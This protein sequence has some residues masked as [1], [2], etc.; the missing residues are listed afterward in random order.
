MND[1]ALNALLAKL[2]KTPGNVTLRLA[3]IRRAVAGG[4]SSRALEL[5]LELDQ[6]NVPSADDRALI[7][8]VFSSAGLDDDA[9]MWGEAPET[10][11]EPQE[12]PLPGEPKKALRL[13]GGTETAVETPHD[14][15]EPPL[16]FADV[17]GLEQVKRDIERRIIA[18]FQQSGL[19]TRFRKKSG[20]GVLLYGPPGCGKTM[21]A[22]ATAGEC[23]FNFFSVSISD[24]LNHYVGASEKQLTAIF[25]KARS[26]T[27]SV[28]FFDEIDA[29]G[30]KRTTAS[31]THQAQ[32]VSHFLAEMDGSKTRNEGV[33]MLAATNIPWAMDPAFLRPGRF[34]RLFFVPPPDRPAREAILALELAERPVSSDLKLDRLA[35]DTSGLSGADLALIVEQ[36]TDM[37]IDAT[38]E[39]GSEVPI[40]GVMLRAAAKQVRSSVTDWLTTARNHA[41][42]ANESGRYDD[43]LEFLKKHGR[44]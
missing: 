35:G 9:A 2:E 5:A 14:E 40:D 27:P 21:I 36:A 41:T 34:D 24:V 1:A 16:T 23:G 42:Y 31:A 28:L 13:V 15:D 17:G 30:A 22:R 6:S 19:L 33:L 10:E 18:P 37:A 7:R 4:F 32:L 25:D 38:L 44:A 12:A 20:G 39:R 29:L 26:R 43:I 11:E 8:D 3:V